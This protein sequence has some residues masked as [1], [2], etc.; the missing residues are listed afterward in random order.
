MHSALLSQD[1]FSLAEPQMEPMDIKV[2]RAS[3]RKRNKIRYFKDPP[4]TLLVDGL[5]AVMTY[6][7]VDRS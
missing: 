5:H 2:T 1:S 4:K 3:I 7:I 6:R